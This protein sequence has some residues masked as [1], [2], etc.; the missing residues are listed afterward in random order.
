MALV[1][2]LSAPASAVPGGSLQWV[3]EQ[4]WCLEKFTPFNSLGCYNDSGSDSALMMRSTAD[5]YI[6]T[7]EECW[8]ICKGTYGT[9]SMLAKAT[10]PTDTI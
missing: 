3:P 10:G 8:A 6:M 5:Q 7:T 2:P 1:H 4:P 9:R